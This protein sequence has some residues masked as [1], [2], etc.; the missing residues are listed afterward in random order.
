MTPD[1]RRKLKD[2]AERKPPGRSIRFEIS[3][4]SIATVVLTALALWLLIQLW[5]IGMVVVVALIL[6]G[7]LNPLVGW[8][9]KHWVKRVWAVALA[10]IA[11]G[12]CVGLLGLL[13]VPPLGTQ[14]SHV[15]EDLSA[16][17][18]DMAKKLET[19][20][21]TAPLGETVR[22][23]AV[24]K[25]VEGA[26][27]SSAIAISLTVVGVLAY[28]A[29]SIVLAI[30]FIAD[31]QRMR[32]ALYALV[33]RRFH[34]R[35]ARVL[36][37]LETIVGGY[38]RGQVVTS[39]AIGLFSFALLSICRVPNALALAAFASL[40][41]VIPFVG[42]L[43]ATAPAVLAA[44]SRG[45]AVATIVLVAML[46]YQE[47]ESRVVVPRVYGKTL[48]LPSAAVVIALLIG[49]KLGGILGA[50]LALPLAAAVLM[51]VE[52]LRLE[53]PGDDTD[54]L[55]LRERDEQAERTYA[56]RSAGASPEEAGAIAVD[57]EQIRN[58]ESPSAKQDPQKPDTG[59][60]KS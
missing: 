24:D 44:L 17:R 55:A 54:D 38:M 4:A 53:L 15:V 12:V 23:F 7:T 35:L 59:G 22:R 58:S 42:G 5:A 57:I 40:T 34:V 2:R 21:L 51:L 39:I 19:Y 37:N 50:L 10:F 26:T 8:L 33:P 60:K 13:I 46:A 18:I 49:G 16:L 48:R 29:T 56:R 52:E 32:G 45:T 43:L 41:D 28:G 9:E 27:V 6:V 20:R 47:F 30:Y 25:T 31:Q 36:L 3:Y 14:V 1:R 11:V